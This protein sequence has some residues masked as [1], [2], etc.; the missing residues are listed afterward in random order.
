MNVLRRFCS[1]YRFSSSSANPRTVLEMECER[2]ENHWR[3]CLNVRDML[4]IFLHSLAN[5][6]T[7]LNFL[8]LYFITPCSLTKNYYL[9]AEI[10]TK[11]TQ[12]FGNFCNSVK[13]RLLLRPYL[14]TVEQEISTI[15]Q[16]RWDQTRLTWHYVSYNV[17]LVMHQNG[18]VK[19]GGKNFAMHQSF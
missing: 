8:Y 10:R 9:F 7:T 4:H 15:F 18:T 19:V 16:Q 11:L 1:K 2:V 12:L 17:P 14:I 3:N 13:G 5:F 6:W